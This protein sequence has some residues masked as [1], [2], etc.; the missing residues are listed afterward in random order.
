MSNDVLSPFSFYGGKARMAPI[1]CS[2]LDY[3]NT[4]IYLEPFGGAARVLLN[5]PKHKQ[6]LY[7][8][9]GAG[10][11]AFFDAMGRPELSGQVI[12]TLFEIVPSEEIFHEMRDY[13]LEHEST[14]MEY[15]KEQFRRTVY[16][17]KKKYGTEE[18]NRLHRCVLHEEYNGIIELTRSIL[19]KGTLQ[20]KEERLAFIHFGLTYAQYRSIVK[21]QLGQAFDKE[22]EDAVSAGTAIRGDREKLKNA[23]IHEQISNEETLKELAESFMDDYGADERMDKVKMA[24]ATFVTYYMSRDGMGKH[25]SDAK[26]SLDA[27]HRQL[28]RLKDVAERMEDVAVMQLDAIHLLCCY[29]DN[30][31]AMIYLD[32]SYL[33][34]E[35]IEKNL[36]EGIY[37]RSSDFQDHELLA[38]LI[39][40]AK[41][42][43]ILSNYD[44]S[45]YKD[46]LDE[47]HGWRRIEFETTTSV[48]GKEDNLRTEVIW[49]NY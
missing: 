20:E 19:V 46:Y 1:I 3:D 47:T 25:Y 18:L 48:G 41:A 7:N 35:D 17:C 33:D 32:P 36:G 4:D 28:I 11:Y 6:E 45:P 34:P 15:M 29:C 38:T 27:Y 43:I 16:E 44:V 23:F 39:Q 37:N 22:W 31:R 30:E 40:N 13:K 8:D 26:S 2:M 42:K 21:E 9:F 14:L 12:S 5:K 49:R 24:V 10:L